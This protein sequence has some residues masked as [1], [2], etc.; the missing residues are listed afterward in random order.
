MNGSGDE[1]RANGHRVLVFTCANHRYHDFVPLY[2]AAMLA[3]SDEIFCEI[4]VE[5][6]DAFHADHAGAMALLREHFGAERFLIREVP[7][8]Y[9]GRHVLPNKIRFITEPATVS[10]YV[11]IGD[12]DIICLQRDFHRPHLQFMQRTGLPYSNSVRPG[13]DRLSG[14]HFAAYDSYY[15]LPDLSEDEILRGNDERLLYRI[16]EKKGLTIQDREWFRPI[17]GIHPSPNRELERSYRAGRNIP[18][19]SGVSRFR[20]SYAAWAATPFFQTFRK[21]LSDRIQG[22][23]AAIDEVVAGG[24]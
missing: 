20:E 2:I 1:T 6:E 14:C 7:W 17:P 16:V 11:Y 12:V 18:G 3:H 4:G 9:N 5:S 8:T 22:I 21:T 24:R 19:W 23:L 10:D 13:T 15:P